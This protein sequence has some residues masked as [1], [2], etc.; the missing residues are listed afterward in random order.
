MIKP[1]ENP[2]AILMW[3]LITL[4]FGLTGCIA[5]DSRARDESISIEATAN[6]SGR[7]YNF[8]SYRS[9]RAGFMAVYKLSDFLQIYPGHGAHSVDVGFKNSELTFQF[10]DDFG[11]PLNSKT[12]RVGDGLGFTTDGKIE[13]LTTS[14]CGGR[15]TPGFGCGS[16]T[17]ILFVNSQGQLVAVQS[18]GGAGLLGIFPFGVYAELISIFDRWQ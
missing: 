3:I 15:D 9:E 1:S 18:G 17:K 16:I 5:V 14:G 11:K 12:Y 13:L 4:Q 8:A 7:F 2:F 6:L 10:V